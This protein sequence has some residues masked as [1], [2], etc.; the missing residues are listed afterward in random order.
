MFVL[1][2]YIYMYI[3][4]LYNG[5]FIYFDK[6]PVSISNIHLVNGMFF[7]KLYAFQ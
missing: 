3:Y 4:I 5:L 1:Y 7:S 2:K 6:Y